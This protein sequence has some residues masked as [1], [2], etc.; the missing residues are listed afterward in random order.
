MICSLY[1]MDCEEGENMFA[2]HLT[3]E[4]RTIPNQYAN[5]SQLNGTYTKTWP[6]LQTIRKGSAAFGT[7]GQFFKIIFQLYHV[8]SID[9]ETSNHEHHITESQAPKINKN[10]NNYNI[11]LHM[12]KIYV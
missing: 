9:L 10:H 8:S 2:S 4:L 6:V 7:F 5:V 11:G 3:N 1:E 12:R